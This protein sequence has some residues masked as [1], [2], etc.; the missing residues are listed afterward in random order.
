MNNLLGRTPTNLVHA[1][2]VNTVLKTCMTDVNFGSMA[3]SMVTVRL[4]HDSNPQNE[5]VV[6]I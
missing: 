3:M 4:I 5:V 6:Y 1:D 2:D